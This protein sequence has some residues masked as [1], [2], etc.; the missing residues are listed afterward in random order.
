MSKKKKTQR[1][2]VTLLI[3]A[4]LLLIPNTKWT[5]NTS[6]LGFISLVLGTLGSVISVFIPNKY[7]FYFTRTDWKNFSGNED[8]YIKI[9]C[10]KH[11]LGNSPETRIF[12]QKDINI[13]EEV[14]VESNH[15]ENGN[16]TIFAGQV[17]TGKAIIK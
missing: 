9:S 8:F 15:D 10:K 6:F 16:I 12:S 7:V 3:F 1:I 4:V 14:F 11:G 5:D 13:F 17:F 2:S